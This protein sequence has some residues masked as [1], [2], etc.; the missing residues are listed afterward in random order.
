[1]TRTLAFFALLAA[2]PALAETPPDPVATGFQRAATE[3]LAQLQKSGASNVGVLKFLVRHGNGPARDDAGD[4]NMALANK[5]ELALILANTDDRF[6]VL[7]EPSAAV[8][9]DNMASANHRDAT[10]RQAFFRRKFDLSWT[11]AKAT[12]G[13]FVVG[14]ATVAQDL[15]SLTV[16]LQSFTKTGELTTL[17]GGFTAPADPRALADAGFSYI[18]PMPMTEAI[19][20]GNPPP[21]TEQITAAVQSAAKPDAPAESPITW[22]VLYND[23]PVPVIDGRVAEPAVTDRVEFKLANPGPGTFAAVLMVNGEN[24]LDRERSAPAAC[25]KWVLPPA[26]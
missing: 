7:R 9:R 25:R 23:K 20:A 11:D 5:L 2:G 13:A 16:T 26:V 18:L 6:G 15:S 14:L 1:M 10:G 17:P 4:L 12:P 21:R 3:I 19:V 8:V 22:T 24:T